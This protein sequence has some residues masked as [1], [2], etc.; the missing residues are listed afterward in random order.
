MEG[1]TSNVTH[2]RICQLEICQLLG[3]GY[4]V[5]YLEGL[6][7]CQVLVIMSLCDLLSNSMTMLKGEPTFLQVDLSQF[8]TKGQESKALSLS[9]DL[10]PTLASHPTRALPIKVEGQRSMTTEVSK[11]LSWAVLDTSGLA[12]INSTPKRSESLAVAT[13]L[14][15]RLEDSAK[16]V[17]T[18]S[19]VSVP[20][21]M[22]MDDPTLEEIHASPSHPVETP[23]PSSR[24]PSLDVTQLQEEANR[25]LRCLLVTRS[26]INTFSEERSF[27]FWDGLW[28]E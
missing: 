19:Q 27:R 16:P 25:A 2:G 4:Q 20:D 9:S 12:S 23:G 15:L 10:S 3:S 6:N 18:S 8:T 22:E 5:V 11:L 7:R 13:P 1:N 14:P 21:D 17:D 26:T 24:A 28:P